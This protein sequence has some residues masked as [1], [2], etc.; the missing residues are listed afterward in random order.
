MLRPVWVLFPAIALAVCALAGPALAQQPFGRRPFGGR[1]VDAQELQ[2]PRRAPLTLTPSLTVFGEYNDNVNL[3][4]DDKRW[5]FLIGFTPG[6]TLT[7]E[8]PTY[9]LSA[10]YSSTGRIFSRDFDRSRF[11]D[12][13]T[14]FVD[15]LLRV[16]PRLTL[17]GAET[18]AFTTDTNILPV[19]EVSSGRT[20]AWANGITGGASYQLD[21]RTS[22][23]GAASW[24]VQR[25][26]RSDLVDSDV[27]R[28][29]TEVE[30]VL[31][32][33][34][35]ASLGYEFGYFDIR[36]F[37]N[38]TTHTPLVG[39]VYRFSETV[40]GSVRGG[41]TF[42]VPQDSDSLVVPNVRAALTKRFQWG[43][44]TADY[45]ENVGTAGGL[46]GVTLNKSV[47]L[48]LQVTNLMKGL[49]VAAGPRY[50]ERASEDDRI[51]IT[52]YTIPIT[53]TYRITPWMAL[54]GSYEF[55]HQRGRS[56]VLTPAGTAFAGDVDRNR[57]LFG[58]QFGYPIR[59]E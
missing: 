6:L 7:V 26:D 22:V 3:D 16:S 57:V 5:D 25:F 55:F 53:A 36:N 33:R 19:D 40:T 58:L 29:E 13:H 44:V 32:P 35:R 12:N 50:G 23:R 11:F 17:T 28:A 39:V 37:E 56:I 27:Y 14:I 41:P 34:L 59:F 38:V 45:Q 54:V 21:P 4:N 47:G 20:S 9:R 24:T 2:E 46:G 51:D 43:S 10:D 48:L 52:T 18:F 15:G 31:T 30:R 49:I 42:E 8:S 1:P